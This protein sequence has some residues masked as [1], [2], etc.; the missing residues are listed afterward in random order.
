MKRAL[1]LL[2]LLACT[3]IPTVS[4]DNGASFE[5]ELARTPAEKAQGLMFRDS[6]PENN[7]M[8]FIFD[9]EV[10]RNFWMK[11][12]KIP[13]DML[14][15]DKNMIVVEIK[16]SVPPCYDDPCRSYPSKPAQYV[17]EINAGIAEKNNIVLGSKMSL[18]E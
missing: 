3:S 10:E 14:F 5:I 1:L 13:L 4:F 7:G 12:T 2:F 18:S 8:L 6:M 11:N 9:D 17:L 15:L 16:A